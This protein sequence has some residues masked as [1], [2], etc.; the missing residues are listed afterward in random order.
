MAGA[1]ARVA[2]L[3]SR[4]SS[5]GRN[6]RGPASRP[7]PKRSTA[8]D[9][10]VERLDGIP[11]AI[12]LAAARVRMMHP[13]RIAAALD[14]RFRLLTGGSR[15]AM[16]R[17]QTLEASV[18]WSYELLDDD[19]QA[20]AR[21]LSVL[22]G[23]TL[24]A[25]EAVGCDDES[26]RFG[27]LD[28]VD[29]ARRQVVGPGG[30]RRRRRPLPD[31]R[32][33][34]P[35]P[36]GPA[37]RVGRR[38]RGPRSAL[39]VLPRP[40][41]AAGAAASRSATVRQCLAR[42]DAEHDNLD[43]AMEW[44]DAAAR[45]RRDAAIRDGA[46][47]VLGAPRAP[48]KGRPVVRPRARRR[49]RTAARASIRARA[50]WGAAHVALYGDDFETMMVR[51]PQALAMAEAV[52]DDWA[53]ARAL[54]SLGFARAAVRSGRRTRVSWRAASSSDERSA[55]TGRSPMVGR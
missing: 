16:P 3:P 28:V 23:F 14:D 35:V 52:G 11:L 45:D 24:D 30:S 6:R 13:T 25:A 43:T 48:R 19:E 1:V 10:I 41:R 33:G 9:Q 22:H 38:R 42:L 50:L 37:R 5:S 2:R 49:R 46:H 44:G 54:N 47:A 7:T 51:A 31:A 40:R 20:L 39:R 53:A 21:R 32:I 55:T 29:A 36:P 4:C 26:D 18:A 15:T 8:I 12:E 34:A 27:V 17:Q